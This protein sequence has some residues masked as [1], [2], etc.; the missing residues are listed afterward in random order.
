MEREE[1]LKFCSVCTNRSFNPKVGITCGLTEQ[2]ADFE[3]NCENYVEDKKEVESNKKSNEEEIS[4]TKKSI[5][6]GRISLFCLGGL[7]VLVGF[8][9]AYYI[10]YHHIIFGIIDWFFALIF[11]G[12]AIWSYAKPY[13]ALIIGLVLFILLNLLGAFI[14][15]ATIFSGIIFKFVVIGFLIHGIKNANLKNQK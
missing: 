2:I 9:E 3:G 13:L 4:E 12:L 14:D 15:P 7:Y 1:H 10:E 11:L 8:I 6:I 5:N